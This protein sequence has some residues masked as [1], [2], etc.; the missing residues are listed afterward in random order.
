MSRYRIRTRLGA[1]QEECE[2]LNHSCRRNFVMANSSPAR[3]YG[4]AG[5][6]VLLA[7]SLSLGALPSVAAAN[8]PNPDNPPVITVYN[9]KVETNTRELKTA[10]R[11]NKI[12][13][14]ASKLPAKTTAFA[15]ALHEANHRGFPFLNPIQTVRVEGPFKDGTATATHYVPGSLIDP[16]K[17][18]SFVANIIV[19]GYGGGQVL[20]MNVVKDSAAPVLHVDSPRLNTKGETVLKVR[21]TGYTG[22]A[23]PHGVRV[24]VSDTNVWVPG[25]FP[26]QG[27]RFVAQVTVPASQI[28]NGAFETEV[29]VPADVAATL[30]TSH[31]Y[32]AGTMAAGVEGAEYGSFDAQKPL[33]LFAQE[34]VVSA[35][36]TY[37]PTVAPLPEATVGVN[38]T[39]AP[40]V[41]PLPEATVGVN[42]TDA[43]TVAPLPEATI[44]VNPTDAPTVAPLP[45]ATVGVNPTDAPTVAPLPEATVGVNPTDAPTV[46]PLPEATVGVNPTDA[47]TVPALPEATV[48]VNPTDAPTVPALPEATIGV[49]P[50]DA[51]TVPALPEAPVADKTPNADKLEDATVAHPKSKPAQSKPAQSK[52]TQEAPVTAARSAQDT[53]AKDSPKKATLANT[54]ASSVGVIVVLGVAAICAGL[55]LSVLRSRRRS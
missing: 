31:K 43:P 29:K 40:T 6:S 17:N 15:P 51:P 1:I 49:N 35:V 18:Y 26:Q 38:P 28:H 8:T 45:E 55:G 27:M 52:P 3:R 20:R 32:I 24:V 47:P 50:T 30:N 53:P 44:G 10:L 11:L 12:T 46:A 22:E 34:P 25:R 19:D 16:A 37:A 7:A 42:P 14:K 23:T 48:G 54:G 41:A 9:Y 4:S 13:F 2:S 5:A 21:G 33:E 36:P 39:D